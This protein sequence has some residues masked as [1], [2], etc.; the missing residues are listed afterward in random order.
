MTITSLSCIRGD[1]VS[2]T[3]ALCAPPEKN[4]SEYQWSR[5]PRAQNDAGH[6]T[7]TI[8]LLGFQSRAPRTSSSRV[9][10]KRRWR[11]SMYAYSII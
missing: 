7:I 2:L 8:I 6:R 5:E 9:G 10:S 11:S 1:S 3:M 4:A